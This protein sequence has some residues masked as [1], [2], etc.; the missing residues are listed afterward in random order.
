MSEPASQIPENQ[1]VACVTF[2]YVLAS[3]PLLYS[4]SSDQLGMVAGGL[5]EV[6]ACGR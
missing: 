5:G 4:L 6:S 1:T 2:I 3:L